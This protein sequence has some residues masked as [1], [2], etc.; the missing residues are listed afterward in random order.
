MRKLLSLVIAL[1]VMMLPIS[2]LMEAPAA[3]AVP[4]AE[5]TE[6]PAAEAAPEATA[7][8]EAV[9]EVTPA[10]TSDPTKVVATVDGD[11]ILL[12]DVEGYF[13]TLA[14]QYSSYVDVNQESIRSVLMEQALEYAIQVK[15][16]QHEAAR[17]GLDKLTDEEAAS[18]DQKAEDNYNTAL[19]N[20]STYL[21]ESGVAEEDAKAQA[22]AYFASQGYALEKVKEQYRMSQ[23]LNKLY[24]SIIDPVT[25]S[26]EDVKATY[27]EKVASEKASYDADPAAYCTAVI[28]GNTT[29]YTPEGIRAVKH[30]LIKPEKID[31]INTLKG[32]IA[33]A[34]TSEA[35]KAEAQT[36]LD[37]LLKEAQPKVDEVQ[38]KI[39]A[40]EDFQSLIDT[41]GE[42]PGM[43]AGSANAEKGYYVSE[44]ASFDAAFLAT[45][46]AL[47]KV[48]DVSA[49]V[50]G[51]YGYHFIRYESDVPAGAVAYESVKEGLNSEALK[52]AQSSTFSTKLDE[53]KAAAK[54]E[55]FG[56]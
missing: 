17:Q 27:D 23:V 6:A 48:G 49:P 38:A 8:P 46:L 36:Q 55:N 47:E 50:L 9:A 39:D 52:T 30:I 31:E 11:E 14:S 35:D 2:A 3:T 22:E 41:Y 42:D 21:T 1:I 53:L 51:S 7:A 19:T 24:S 4:A 26:D 43:Q 34:E 45:A 16:M 44:G 20:Y 10:P 56:L 37:A 33:N 25:V 29:Y 12:S 54:I 32:T 28:S 15:L 13:Q 40:G 18:L 5:A